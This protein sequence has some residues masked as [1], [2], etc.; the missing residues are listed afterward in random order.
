MQ[1]TKDLIHDVFHLIEAFSIFARSFI[2]SNVASPEDK[3][4]TSQRLKAFG[5]VLSVGSSH[6]S[7]VKGLG[8][9]VVALLPSSVRTAVE[10]WNSS[11]G[12]EFPTMGAWV[13]H[14]ISSGIMWLLLERVSVP[15]LLQERI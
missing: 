10:K 11:G 13:K 3:T 15:G 14:F 5:Q 2:L 9:A 6:P 12:N 7:A 1:F 8:S 4:L